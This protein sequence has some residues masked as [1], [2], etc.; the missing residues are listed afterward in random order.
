MLAR[1]NN[2]V[3]Q[4]QLQELRHHVD[5][6]KNH[7]HAAVAKLESSVLGL[8]TAATESCNAIDHHIEA[9]MHSVLVRRGRQ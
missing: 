2:T 5:V 1:T 8:S 7:L 9:R 6:T 3:D 4:E